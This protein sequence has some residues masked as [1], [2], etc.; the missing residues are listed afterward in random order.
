VCRTTCSAG[1]ADLA[2]PSKEAIL[3]RIHTLT[4]LDALFEIEAIERISGAEANVPFVAKELEG[5]TAIKVIFKRGRL[6]LKY[7]RGGREDEYDDRQFVV[8]LDAAGKNLLAVTST[9]SKANPDIHPDKP[10]GKIATMFRDELA[11]S[12]PIDPETP[13]AVISLKICLTL[14]KT[15]FPRIGSFLG[16]PIRRQTV[17]VLGARVHGNS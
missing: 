1:A 2:T 3:D 9:V 5:T 15:R 7:I 14:S 16:L 6:K 10:L 17:V 12:D 8:L 13:I 4:G 11:T